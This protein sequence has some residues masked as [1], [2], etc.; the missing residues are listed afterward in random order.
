MVHQPAKRGLIRRVAQNEITEHDEVIRAG[1]DFATGRQTVSARAADFLLIILQRLRQVEMNHR[2]DV[3]LV[4]PHAE[5]NRGDNDIAPP[6]HE[7]VLGRSTHLVGHACVVGPRGETAGFQMLGDFF[8]RVLEGH[9]ND[10]GMAGFLAEAL[11]EEIHSLRIGSGCYMDRE[12]A[13]MER[14]DGA[15]LLADAKAF[16]NFLSH[17]WCRC[18][19]EGQHARDAEFFCQSRETQVVRPEIVTPLGNAMRLVDRQQAGR[20]FAKT[21]DE[22]LAGKP[23]RRDIEQLEGT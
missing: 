5:R 2:A 6:L 23:L 21:R 10:G 7:V 13:A 22:S 9:I 19:G 1:E 20:V 3:G 15:V 8:G 17:G 4:D 14:G 12:V 11:H 16:A 18:R